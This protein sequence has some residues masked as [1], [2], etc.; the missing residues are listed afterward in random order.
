MGRVLMNPIGTQPA[1]VASL[2][3]WKL[4]YKTN[5][6]D[7]TAFGDANKAIVPDLAQITGSFTG[8]W[9]DTETKPFATAKFA[10]GGYFYGYPDHTGVA[11]SYAY[12]PMYATC[13]ID[14]PV[15][16]PVKISGTFEASGNWYIG[17]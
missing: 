13:D 14:V 16:G 11:G 1:A 4:S 10:A 8:F 5:F 17:L 2:D 6:L 9:D 3:N 15:S 12:G 7:V